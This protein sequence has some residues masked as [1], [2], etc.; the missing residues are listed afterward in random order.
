MSIQNLGML[1]HLFLKSSNTIAQSATSIAQVTTTIAKVADQTN[2]LSLNAAIEAEKAGEFGL[3]F[4][5]WQ[6][7]FAG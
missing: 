7:K 6:K 3:A 4:L 1:K 2:M 5:W